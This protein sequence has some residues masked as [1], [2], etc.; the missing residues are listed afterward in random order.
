MSDHAVLSRAKVG[1]AMCLRM[2]CCIPHRRLAQKLFA[3]FDSLA[4]LYPYVHYNITDTSKASKPLGFS[5][6][7]I[8]ATTSHTC[9]STIHA[10]AP[11]RHP[12]N[13]RL[14]PHQ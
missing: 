13:A 14:A 10:T 1:S 3:A 4:Y 2:R 9:P 6:G 8:L 12:P 5:L 11:P 7:E